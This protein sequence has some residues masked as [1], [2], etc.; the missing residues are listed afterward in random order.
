MDC[1]GQTVMSHVLIMERKD[2]SAESNVECELSDQVWTD[3]ADVFLWECFI[4]VVCRNKL[5]QTFLL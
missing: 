2:I 3:L 5:C 1:P 4:A